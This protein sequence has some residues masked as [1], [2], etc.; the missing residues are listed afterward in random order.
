MSKENKTTAPV[1]EIVESE[2]DDVT[3]G[4]AASGR[5]WFEPVR[6]TIH[7]GGKDGHVWVKCKNS[8]GAWPFDCPC[9]G[10]DRC[11]DQ[12]HLMEH[13]V[14]HVW[15]PSPFNEYN[16]KEAGKA[17]RDLDLGIIKPTT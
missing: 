16:H 9:R 4:T 5:C 8:C 15:V 7:N 14:G 1:N 10:S 12:W 11:K 13:I 2:L 3:G 17:V 6:P